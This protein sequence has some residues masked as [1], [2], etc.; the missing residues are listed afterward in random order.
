[1]FAWHANMILLDIV[2]I[3]YFFIIGHYYNWILC[4][5]TF[6]WLQASRPKCFRATRDIFIIEHFVPSLEKGEA[7]S[8]SWPKKDPTE[9]KIKKK[10]VVVEASRRCWGPERERA[11]R[12]PVNSKLSFCKRQTKIAL[13]LRSVS[14]KSRDDWTVAKLIDILYTGKF[15]FFQ[16]MILNRNLVS[17]FIFIVLWAICWP[18]KII[19][20]FSSCPSKSI[21]IMTMLEEIHINCR[22]K[23]EI[24]LEQAFHFWLGWLCR[25]NLSHQ[26]FLPKK[27]LHFPPNICASDFPAKVG[28]AA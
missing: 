23:I 1:M 8:W 12:T 18:P 26:K 22:K 16:N 3:E 24:H 27:L 19:K 7:K 11:L 15:H 25:L 28:C 10:M 17:S 20:S 2:I 6:G 14:L 9:L 21:W 13:N 4:L 5:L